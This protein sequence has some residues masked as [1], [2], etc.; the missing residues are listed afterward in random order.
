MLNKL[1][2]P[3]KRMANWFVKSSWKIKIL[4][5]AM[6]VV[7]AWFISTRSNNEPEYTTD[8]VKK[9]DITEVVSE[10]GT[11]ASVGSTAVYSPTNGLVD[12]VFVTNNQEV[13]RN[14]KLFAVKS[15]AT[16]EEITTAY[17]AYQAAASAVQQAEN[18]RRSTT[19]T[20][21]R[22]HDDVKDNDDDETFLQKETR[23]TAEVAHDNAYDALLAARASLVS[24]QVA[25]QATQDTIVVAPI[26]GTISNLS[27][28]DGAAV[29]INSPLAPV[30]PV[31]MIGNIGTPE[32]KISVGE[33]DINKV[34]VGKEVVLEV[35]AIDNKHYKGVV[36]RVDE[37]GTVTQGVV[38]FSIYIEIIDPDDMLRTGMGV[39]A[40]IIT[41]KLEDILSVPNSAIKRS[42]GKRA[43]RV[44]GEKGEIEFVYV[45]TGVKG[46]DRTQILSGLSEGQLIISST[47]S[48]SEKR[49]SPFG[50]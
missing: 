21:D 33:N 27:V 43:V 6:L 5:V 11:I 38:N 36:S 12:E 24:A 13:K 41:K 42:D 14:E 50:F 39:D 37:L 44:P 26:D 23:T 48:D 2:T 46:G 28:T 34:K 30:S 49:T 7:G 3:I 25:Y 31:L 32:V 15:T 19:A 10:S 22:V 9:A 17:A 40:E 47:P 29:A 35:D 4:I 18:I 45:E 1:L 16:K 8:V 20:V